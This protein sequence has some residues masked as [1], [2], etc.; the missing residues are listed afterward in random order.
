MST[1]KRSATL[2]IVGT[3]VVGY[4]STNVSTVQ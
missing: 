4:Q 2:I 1:Q 3:G